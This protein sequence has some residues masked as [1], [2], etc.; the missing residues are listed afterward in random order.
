[1]AA[2]SLQPIRR[3]ISAVV[4]G[5]GLVQA[6]A[7]MASVEGLCKYVRQQGELGERAEQEAQEGQGGEEVSSA[8]ED[9]PVG[10]EEARLQEPQPDPRHEVELL[11]AEV[12]ALRERVEVVEG[13]AVQGRGGGDI[14]VDVG[15]VDAGDRGRERRSVAPPR[16]VFP[17]VITEEAEPGEEPVYG[18]AAE[19]VVEWRQAW[20][21]RRSA[22]HTLAWLRAERRWLDLELRLIGVFGLTPPRS[23]RHGPNDGVN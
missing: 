17:E 23:R 16:R 10:G 8:S 13:Q 5:V 7:G 20:V 12:A 15:A 22:R 21:E 2:L 11:W 1:M 14:N 18:A 4:I 9:E 6:L 19:L 3:G